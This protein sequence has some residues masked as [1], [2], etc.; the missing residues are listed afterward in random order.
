MLWRNAQMQMGYSF[1]KCL[2]RCLHRLAYAAERFGLFNAFLVTLDLF[3]KHKGICRF[4]SALTLYHIIDISFGKIVDTEF[5]L[6][7][8]LRVSVETFSRRRL[9]LSDSSNL[10]SVG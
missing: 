8:K 9:F 10:F 2:P 4:S 1:C 3:S 5:F 6:Y 7:R